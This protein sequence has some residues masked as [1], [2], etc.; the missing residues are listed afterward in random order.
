M[1][2]KDILLYC[3]HIANLQIFGP[4]Q[5]LELAANTVIQQFTGIKILSPVQNFKT[6]SRLQY[7]YSFSEAFNVISFVRK[8]A[9]GLQKKQHAFECERIQYA[10]ILPAFFIPGVGKVDINTIKRSSF[11]KRWQQKDV[12]SQHKHIV[13]IVLCCF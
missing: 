9:S 12:S 4:K 1:K 13:Q 7:F 6:L 11:K 5:P 10:V 2:R 3:F 8:K